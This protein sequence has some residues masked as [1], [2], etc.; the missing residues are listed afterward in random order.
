MTNWMY[1]YLCKVHILD[2]F[3]GCRHQSLVAC[4]FLVDPLNKEYE[5]VGDH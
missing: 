2:I 1:L 4:S 5:P 3:F